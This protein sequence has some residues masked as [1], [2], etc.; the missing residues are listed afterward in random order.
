MKVKEAMHKGVEWVGPDTPIVELAKL[1]RKHDVGAIPIGPQEYLKIK[2]LVIDAGYSTDLLDF[3]LMAEMGFFVL[4][5]DR[6]Q[7]THE[8]SVR[9][10]SW[11]PNL[12]PAVIGPAVWS[13]P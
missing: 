10:F 5:G 4:T 3:V 11:C 6:Y 1:M 12:N 2:S 8:A 13:T 9:T 7:M